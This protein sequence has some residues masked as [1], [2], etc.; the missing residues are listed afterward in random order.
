MDRFFGK[1]VACITGSLMFSE[2]V[3]IVALQ[4]A[5]NKTIEQL[6]SLRICLKYHDGIPMQYISEY[7][8]Q[9]FK[10]VSFEKMNEFSEW[11]ND[12]AQTPFDLN[13]SLSMFFIIRVAQQVGFVVHLH[14][15][16]ADAWTLSLLSR[17]VMQNLKSEAVAVGS[18]LDFL[19]SEHEYMLSTRL[20]MDRS[21]FLA[22]HEQCLEPVYMC[23]KQA[24]GYAARRLSLTIDLEDATKIKAFCSEN[25]LTPYALFLNTLA[26]YF[27]RTKGARDIYIG[28]P[29]LNRAGQRERQTAGVFINTVPLLL[30]IDE[31]KSSYENL[32]EN[33][34]RIT[35]VFRHHRYPYAELLRDLRK[36]YGFT[37][38]LYDVM[39]NYQN[40]TMADSGIKVQWHFCGHQGESLNIN[41]NDRQCEGVYHMDYDYQM[42]LFSQRD[43]EQMHEHLLNLIHDE[44]EHRE[45]KPQDL[46]L[47]SASELDNVVNGFNAT[48][49]DY[50]RDKCVHQLFEEQVEKTPEAVA[51]T[52]EGASYTYR[53]INEMSNSLA[54]RLRE[55]G[56]ARGDIV[57][58]I[59]RRN[60]KIIVAQMAVLKA[61]G[62]YLPIDPNYPPARI[63]FMLDDTEC[64]IALVYDSRVDGVDAIN[65]EDDSIFYCETGAVMNINEA[66]DLCYLIFTSGS[67]GKP[68]GTMLTHSNVINYCSDNNNNVV[69]KIITDDANS[70]IS[71][72][73][74]GFD[75]FVTESLLPL[76]NGR[77]IVFANERESSIQRDLNKLVIR[78]KA[79]VLQTTPTK[80]QMLMRDDTDNEY[81][82]LIKVFIIGGEVFSEPLLNQLKEHTAAAIF[83]IYGPTE[84]TV[85]SSTSCV[86]SNDIT[87]GRPIANTQIYILDE[88]L[89][90]LPI[91][92]AGELCIAGAGV[93][94]GY[95][96]RPV[97]TA[98]KFVPNPFGDGSMYKTG[99]LAKW[100][101]DGDLIYIGRMDNQAKI[102]GQRIELDEIEEA[103]VASTGAMQ[104]VAE[105]KADDNGRQYLCAYYQGPEIDAKTIRVKLAA[106]LPQYMVPH[107]FVQMERF[108][109]T[110]SGKTDRKAFPL[111][112][113]AH[114]RTGIE[115]AEPITDT[116]KILV[117]LMRKVLNTQGIGLYEGF[118]EMGGDSLRAIELVSK[119]QYDGLYFSLQDVYEYPTAA[120]LAQFLQGDD[121]LHGAL[122]S[123]SQFQ[124]IH[125]LLKKNRISRQSAPKQSLGDVL[126]T[127]ATGWLGAHVLDAFL[128]EETGTAYC[129]VRAKDQADGR[130][131]IE[132]ALSH[133]FGT[134]YKV[135]DRVIAIAGDVTKNVDLFS[136]IDTIIHCAANV[137]HYGDY[138]YSYDINV[139]G[140]RSMIALAWEKSAR[141][142]HIS[143]ASVSGNSFDGNPGSPPMIFNETNLFIGQ[144]LN[145][146][147]VR[148]KFEAEVAVFEARMRGLEACVIR[149]GNL[150]NRCS[151]FLFQK[152]Y[153]EN[154]TLIRLKAFVDL[155]LYPEEVNDWPL[156]FSPVDFSSSAIIRLAQYYHCDISVFHAYNHK[157]LRFSDLARYLGLKPV[158]LSEFISSV[159]DTVQQT[160]Q[161]HIHEAFI[162]DIGANGQFVLRNNIK[163][164]NDFT[165]WY[166]K[167]IGF[168]W[169]EIDDRYIRGYIKHFR[170]IGYWTGQK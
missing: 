148:S 120:S 155:G 94:R 8:Y 81:L 70:I 103:I 102:R 145:N 153:Q 167:Q 48:T 122:Y 113:F 15:L 150:S 53:Q 65:L 142:F 157:V 44:I 133:Y 50:P 16:T 151:D 35:A 30:H 159:R 168:D 134:K 80:L 96:N 1:S 99:D 59:A 166:L 24:R 144:P 110:P 3:D 29:V 125:T 34:A 91:G 5:L 43:I 39:L 121:R 146:V 38:R 71:T 101:E 84:T 11:V 97:L 135:C 74:I 46:R 41:I 21:Y 19:A 40:A 42:E 54:H 164:S 14:H 78:T 154:A 95:L 76:I 68:K 56:I 22:N 115:F 36:R 61:G 28:T 47:L 83:N 25:N 143:T 123:E 111:P 72:T 119:A 49:T 129:L 107:F 82:G 60:Y 158:P 104:V 147:Y 63:K 98:E 106:S 114:N 27:F 88:F 124:E 108:P 117:A 12:L 109:T 128:S 138:Q 162:H 45:K 127:G 86:S 67:T 126:I 69:H 4:E 132:E 37:G 92:V 140:T 100:R 136:G 13:D 105:I 169:C 87:I 18:Y 90:P 52:F 9:L 170:D 20:A 64:K 51:V 62:A 141:L 77:R 79:E 112:D 10:I 163:L 85:W 6:D 149:V 7:E 137:K 116:E 89:N 75:I 33:S 66:Y 118:F 93:G 130:C 31:G 17:S 165:Q 23:D 152:N 156:E 73:T 57:A 139:G 26:I 160:G 161:E 2:P 55:R 32:K 131:R 58:I